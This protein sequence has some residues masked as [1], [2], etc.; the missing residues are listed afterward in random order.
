MTRVILAVLIVSLIF[1][2][3]D[4]IIPSNGF[5]VMVENGGGYTMDSSGSKADSTRI[6]FL[7]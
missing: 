4:I 7:I 5:L 2:G 6:L 1:A 3:N